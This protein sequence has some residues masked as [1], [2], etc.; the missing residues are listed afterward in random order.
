LNEPI[1]IIQA[2]ERCQPEV[3]VLDVIMPGLSGYDVC[4]EIRKHERWRSLAV[5]FLT[6][7]SNQEGRA[8]A[9]RAG[10]DDLIAKPVLKEELIARVS[11]LR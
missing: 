2:L 3:V 6:A 5:L 4:R 1:R 7:K 11:F 10:G 9:F 8:L